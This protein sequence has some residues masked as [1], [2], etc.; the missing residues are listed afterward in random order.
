MEKIIVPPNEGLQE[1]FTAFHEAGFN[2][3]HV[4]GSVRDMILGRTPKDFDLTTD[5][6]PEETKGV[7][8]SA[9]FKTFPLGEAFGTIAAHVGDQIIEITT[10]RLDVTRGRHPDVAFTKDLKEDLSRRDLTINSIALDGEGNVIDPFNGAKDIARR[11]IRTTGNP[12]ERFGED[13]LRMLRAVRFASQLGFN[14]EPRTQQAIR[15]LIPSILSVSRERWL[16]ELNK[17]LLGAYVGKGLD[18]LKESGLLGY[19]L[20]E[21]YPILVE[22]TG[23]LHSKN[24]WHHTRVVVSKAKSD[25]L[26]RWAALLHDIAKPQTRQEMNDEVHFYGHEQLGAELVDGIG[27]R[28]HMSNEMRLSVKG[29]VALHQR[30]GDCVSRKND[31]PVSPSA[32]RRVARDCEELHCSI[33]DLIELFAADSS[34]NRP[35]TRERQQ[36]HAELL[37]EAVGQMREDELRPKLPSGIGQVIM[38]HFGVSPGPKVGEFKKILDNMLVSGEIDAETSTEDM[39]RKLEERV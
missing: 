23:V 19:I 39:M 15:A 28:L 18:L 6:K 27:R 32:L 31:P 34:S 37:R 5:A 2:L 10:H 13:P 16:E 9:G 25:L 24:L 12:M 14:I 21:V 1:L 36:A 30:I 38:E 33:E 7:L 29:L 3:Y 8:E 22:P 35:E 17:L 26:V 11:L 4:G 20:P